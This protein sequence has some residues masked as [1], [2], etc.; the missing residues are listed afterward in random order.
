MIQKL[1]KTISLQKEF[2]N[3]KEENEILIQQV[4]ALEHTLM[5]KLENFKKEK[6]FFL[7]LLYIQTIKDLDKKVLI[8][9]FLGIQVYKQIKDKTHRKFYLFGICVLKKQRKG[10]K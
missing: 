4:L 3:L 9:K 10:K 1:D 7:Y 8:I 2:N 6:N 5:N